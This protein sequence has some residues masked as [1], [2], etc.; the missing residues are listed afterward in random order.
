MPLFPLLLIAAAFWGQT[1]DC[2]VPTIATTPLPAV[3]GLEVAGTFDPDR[4]A[5]LV[6]PSHLRIAGAACM[7]VTHEYGHLLGLP[8]SADPNSVM[9]PIMRR[10]VWPCL[11]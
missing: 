2:G 3:A 6:D 8:H 9:Y 10:A 5:I 11:W 1:P 7:A 4:C